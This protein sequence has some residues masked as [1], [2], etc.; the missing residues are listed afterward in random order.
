MFRS[1]SW[2]FLFGLRRLVLKRCFFVWCVIL[3]I[4]RL[5]I[6]ILIINIQYKY[7]VVGSMVDIFVLFELYIYWVLFFG[8]FIFF[9]LCV[10]V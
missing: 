10:Y 3:K 5:N 8:S 1:G 9:F 2:W 4:D 6:D 7:I